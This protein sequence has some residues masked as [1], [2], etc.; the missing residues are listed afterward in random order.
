MCWTDLDKENFIRFKN[1]K[2]GPI[3]AT[4]RKIPL[5][6]RSAASPERALFSTRERQPSLL[7]NGQRAAVSQGVSSGF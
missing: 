5:R 1:H 4:K 2:N 7:R 6:E 3:F